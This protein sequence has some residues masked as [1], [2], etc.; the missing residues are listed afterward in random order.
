MLSQN[1]KSDKIPHICG[2]FLVYLHR[3]IH[4]KSPHKSSVLIHHN[5]WEPHSV[6]INSGDGLAPIRRQDIVQTH[7]DQLL[8]RQMF[9]LANEL[10]KLMETD[11]EIV[12]QQSSS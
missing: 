5:L 4:H 6:S 7:D 9:S 11:L 10:I 2:I 3:G 12:G 1:L 8:W